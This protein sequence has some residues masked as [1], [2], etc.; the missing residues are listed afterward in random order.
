MLGHGSGLGRDAFLIGLCFGNCRSPRGFGTLDGDIAIG[1]GGGHFGIALDAG[2]VRAAH[3]GDVLVFVTHF[4]YGEA[5]DF[6]AH[7][8]H[9]IGAGGAHTSADHFRFFDDLLDGELADDAAE[10]AFHHQTD[11]AI[12]LGG[13]F[14]QE[15]VRRR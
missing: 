12:T 8:A 5:D 7:L 10:M 11:Q 9:V 2:D 4:L 3:V 15:I 14:G 13:R 6:E 1:F